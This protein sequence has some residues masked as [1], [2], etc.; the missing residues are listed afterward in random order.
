MS[1][2]RHKEAS[3]ASGTTEKGFFSVFPWDETRLTEQTAR[4]TLVENFNV[5]QCGSL[6]FDTARTFHSSVCQH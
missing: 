1:H 5:F 4:G 3:L 6:V 2:F